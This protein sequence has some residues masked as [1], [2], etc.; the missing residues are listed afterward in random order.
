MAAEVNKEK[1][2]ALQLTIDRMEKSYGK[3][4]V[5]KLGDNVVE[6]LD[7]ISTGSLGMD[8]ALGIGG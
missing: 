3:G 8:L 2:K 4:A 1:L 6:K 7:V 5:M